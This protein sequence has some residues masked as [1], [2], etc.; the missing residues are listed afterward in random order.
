MCSIGSLI[1]KGK[2]SFG[3]RTRSQNMQ[4][5]IAAAIFEQ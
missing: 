4:L 5:Q 1:P 3:N 2:E